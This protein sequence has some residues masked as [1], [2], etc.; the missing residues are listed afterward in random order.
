MKDMTS[1]L[2]RLSELT[3]TDMSELDDAAIESQR[4]RAIDYN[5]KEYPGIPFEQIFQTSFMQFPNEMTKIYGAIRTAIGVV[6]DFPSHSLTV[7]QANISTDTAIKVLR[8]L[9]SGLEYTVK[10]HYLNLKVSGATATLSCGCHPYEPHAFLALIVSS[11]SDTMITFNRTDGNLAKLA[12][13]AQGCFVPDFR[14][15]A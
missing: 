9:T 14:V 7:N 12:T 3:G 6:A 10:A 15:R 5:K 4:R 8:E 11:P 2:A 1:S 13:A